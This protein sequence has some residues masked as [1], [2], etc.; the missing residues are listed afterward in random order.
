M[1][2]CTLVHAGCGAVGAGAEGQRCA[3]VVLH[4]HEVAA[5]AAAVPA[6]PAVHGDDVAI[7]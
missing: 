3:G 2:H 1:L 6:V 4:D 7:K 5:A